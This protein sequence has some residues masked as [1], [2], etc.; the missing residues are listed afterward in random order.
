MKNK[1]KKKHMNEKD[2]ILTCKTLIEN[3]CSSENIELSYGVRFVSSKFG[4]SEKCRKHRRYTDKIANIVVYSIINKH[5]QYESRISVAFDMPDRPEA[6]VLN[7]DSW[8]SL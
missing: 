8:V 7:D 6:S 3:V 5:Q 4:F 1:H 2:F